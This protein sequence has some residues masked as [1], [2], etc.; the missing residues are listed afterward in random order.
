[1]AARGRIEGVDPVAAFGP[2]AAASLLRLAGFEDAGDLV[3]MGTLDPVT[4]D[5][6]AFEELVGTH[7]GL[8]G[9]QTDPFIAYPPEWALTEDPPIDAPAI[10]RLLRAWM[11]MLGTRRP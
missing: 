11:T 3:A 7:G 9:W 10:H 6:V 4:G 5:I 2:N 8:G 1:V